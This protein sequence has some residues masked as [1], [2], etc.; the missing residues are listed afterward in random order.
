MKNIC[1]TEMRLPSTTMGHP[2]NSFDSLP[3]QKLVHY[4]VL[5]L[6]D[7]VRS[8]FSFPMILYGWVLLLQQL[9]YSF[10]IQKERKYILVCIQF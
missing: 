2:S 5:V 9:F 7:L 4:S 1:D 6:S 10:N 8:L 3:I